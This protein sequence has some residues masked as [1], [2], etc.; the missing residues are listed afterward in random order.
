LVGGPRCVPSDLF[1][2]RF[3][4]TS[5]AAKSLPGQ[6][7][8]QPAAAEEPTAADEPRAA[9]EPGATI[10]AEEQAVVEELEQA[11]PKEPTPPEEPEARPQRR[12]VNLLPPK[13]PH[14]PQPGE[15][16]D[17]EMA[18]DEPVKARIYDFFYFVF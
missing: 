3:N 16:E 2:S 1:I 7:P 18:V 11:S 5:T 15:D 4:N 8:K 13:L 14:Q 9:D 6:T 17:V 12:R 10:A